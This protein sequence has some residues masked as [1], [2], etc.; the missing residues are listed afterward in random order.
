MAIYKI[1]AYVTAENKDVLQNIYNKI[2][3][4][5]GVTNPVYVEPGTADPDSSKIAKEVHIP[6]G[7]RLSPVRAGAPA[8][9]FESKLKKALEI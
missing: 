6:V 5:E 2:A 7:H 8:G 1:V 3:D 9:P 4:V